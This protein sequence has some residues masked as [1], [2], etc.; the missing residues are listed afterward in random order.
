MA[1]VEQQ[2]QTAAEK[3]LIRILRA[4]HLAER[5]IL[6]D[7]DELEASLSQVR[8]KSKG[9]GGKPLKGGSKP[10]KGK[11]WA[12]HEDPSDEQIRYNFSD[13]DIPET[14]RDEED[15]RGFL[16]E[17]LTEAPGDNPFLCDCF[18]Y[19]AQ[20]R[21]V[22]QLVKETG[23]DRY[24]THQMFDGQYRDRQDLRFVRHGV[25]ERIAKSFGVCLPESE[26][27]RAPSAE[28]YRW[29]WGYEDPE[30]CIRDAE[31]GDKF[32]QF[33][34]GVR[35]L[36]G[37]GCAVDKAKAAEWLQKSVEQSF[38]M[39]MC[40]LGEMYFNGDGF[41]QDFERA[42]EWWNKAAEAGETEAMFHLGEMYETGIGV[43][44]DLAK[45]V[46]WY[47][48]CL[49]GEGDGPGLDLS[50]SLIALE[51]GL[52][53][54]I[55]IGMLRF[56]AKSFGSGHGN[57][58]KA[59]EQ[60][61]VG[62]ASRDV[63]EA[64][65]WWQKVAE[66]CR[67]DAE[68]GDADAQYKLAAMYKLGKGVPKDGEKA[69]EWYKKAAKQYYQRAER[70]DVDAQCRLAEMY[71]SDTFDFGRGVFRNMIWA[72]KWYT[73]AAEAGSAHAQFRLG[74]MYQRRGY[75]KFTLCRPPKDAKSLQKVRE[76]FAKAAEW[77]AKAAD[78]GHVAAQRILGGLYFRG[79]FFQQDI[80]KA[81][82]WWEKAAEQ[83]HVWAL[84]RLGWM[85]YY[86]VRGPLDMA[87]AA[88]WLQ[89]AAEQGDLEAKSDLKSLE[90]GSADVP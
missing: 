36:E 5:W 38:E 58:A 63:K 44:K 40:K 55:G 53:P 89:R 13:W 37:I 42:F 83:G 16:I 20:A 46:G 73:R 8:S 69:N 19:A 14:L 28:P 34:T 68:R 62:P 21:T 15:I 35:Y 26:A 67:R 64:A 9:R 17:A 23:A 51:H 50:L 45:A 1:Q 78:Q 11:N 86:G 84:A 85:Y 4:R 25:L 12:A 81:L 72:E 87:K 90:G 49:E 22:N 47:Y 75:A 18:A 57:G 24:L 33:L 59:P 74:K 76:A 71:D 6:M 61:G 56:L 43:P 30:S 82:E 54:D 41:S 77:Y 29:W 66:Q 79:E 3:Q 10:S 27:Y 2:E 48:N 39:A 70:G 7:A 32:A 88:E 31:M 60:I 52:P 65:G 80:K